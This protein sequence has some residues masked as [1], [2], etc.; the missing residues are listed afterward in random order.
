MSY[1]KS[2]TEYC[3]WEAPERERITNYWV[4]EDEETTLSDPAFTGYQ[5]VC[6]LDQQG[7]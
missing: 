7:K 5:G 3:C 6:G 4:V 1:D 2:C